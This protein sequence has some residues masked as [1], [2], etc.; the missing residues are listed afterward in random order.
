MLH[1][2]L[3]EVLFLGSF[4]L[5]LDPILPQP[6]LQISNFQLCDLMT[7]RREGGGRE[8]ERERERGREGGREGG[9]DE[10]FDEHVQ[11]FTVYTY[12]HTFVQ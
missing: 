1:D 5:E 3:H 2:K 8:G 11:N 12:R 10:V 9:R 6:L 4:G 7:A